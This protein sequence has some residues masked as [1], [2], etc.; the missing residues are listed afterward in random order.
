MW[1]VLQEDAERVLAALISLDLN[2]EVEGTAQAA[3]HVMQERR[4]EIEREQ[5]EEASWKHPFLEEWDEGQEEAP[6]ASPGVPQTS[7]R[8]G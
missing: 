4:V 8:E 3:L 7:P 2:K 1:E 6:R 5:L